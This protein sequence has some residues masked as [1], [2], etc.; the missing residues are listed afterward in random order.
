MIY[1]YQ[2]NIFICLWKVRIKFVKI[3]TTIHYKYPIRGYC[4][5]RLAL[6]YQTDKSWRIWSDKMTGIC[7]NFA[8]SLV[9]HEWVK[10]Q[11]HRRGCNGWKE[12]KTWIKI[13]IKIIISY[14]LACIYFS[15]SFILSFLC[16]QNI[17]SNLIFMYI[18]KICL[19]QRKLVAVGFETRAWS[20]LIFS[21]KCLQNCRNYIRIFLL[22]LTWWLHFN[23]FK[24]WVI[25]ELYT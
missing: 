25:I 11:T 7:T 8:I 17:S 23:L 16:F 4:K 22:D 24:I 9:S 3:H 2:G 14:P 13:N 1:G 19:A 15:N 18:F 20:S 10:S 6:K 21:R 5:I 12:K